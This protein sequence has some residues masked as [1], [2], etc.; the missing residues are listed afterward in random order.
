MPWHLGH[1]CH[2]LTGNSDIGRL[3]LKCRRKLHH[4]WHHMGKTEG[5][6]AKATILFWDILG[7]LPHIS[8][9]REM[10]CSHRG[11]SQ[12]A[13]TAS[14]PGTFRAAANSADVPGL[15][16]CYSQVLWGQ[17]RSWQTAETFKSVLGLVF[18]HASLGH[19]QRAL[20]SFC[21]KGLDL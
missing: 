6:S 1:V 7:A 11:C 3:P 17:R 20:P 12:P 9:W 16:C 10:H 19:A 21:S 2:R 5:E 13:S 14:P 18:V 15:V 4:C 8:K